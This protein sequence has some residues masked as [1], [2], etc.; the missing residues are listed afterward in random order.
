MAMQQALEILESDWKKIAGKWLEK[1]EPLT[2]DESVE[3]QN[4]MELLQQHLV[5]LHAVKTSLKNLGNVRKGLMQIK[6]AGT[7]SNSNNTDTSNKVSPSKL[8]KKLEMR[9]GEINQVLYG[10]YMDEYLVKNQIAALG[11]YR[12]ITMP[13]PNGFICHKAYERELDFIRRSI[14][15]NKTDVE[16]RR[17]MMEEQGGGEEQIAIINHG[18]DNLKQLHLR[19]Y[20]LLEDFKP[21]N[22]IEFHRKCKELLQVLI[23][24]L[25]LC[26]L[27]YAEVWGRKKWTS[28]SNA[29]GWK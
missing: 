2:K 5:S 1:G 25:N 9:K 7:N 24:F 23:C 15:E 3:L 11:D 22:V 16:A 27:V 17:K 6:V 4:N 21:I 12:E 10:M 20:Q 8:I 14:A 26:V 13:L 28:W 19:L 29:K 18:L